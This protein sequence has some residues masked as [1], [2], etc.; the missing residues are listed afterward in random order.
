MEKQVISKRMYVILKES[1]MRDEEIKEQYEVGST[2][3]K[4]LI[5]FEEGE[6]HEGFDRWVNRIL[7]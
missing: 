4:D 7:R 5:Q 6:N 1:G 3:R 2:E